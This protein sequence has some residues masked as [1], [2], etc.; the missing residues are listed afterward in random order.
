MSDQQ[1]PA[2][3]TVVTK[4]E[5][6]A[7]QKPTVNFYDL[8]E[9][10]EIVRS[11]HEFTGYDAR[12]TIRHP[13]GHEYVVRAWSESTDSDAEADNND[14]DFD[15]PTD[16]KESQNFLIEEAAYDRRERHDDSEL[17]EAARLVVASWEHG[18]LALA[19]NN[20]AEALNN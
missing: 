20:L 5:E 12:L 15:D 8:I 2:E 14:V 19:V 10:G 7:S 4:R 6:D 17:R 11:S 13:S 3:A 9:N 16:E 1:L 18:D